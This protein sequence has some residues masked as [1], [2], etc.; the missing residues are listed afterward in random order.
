M[1]ALQGLRAPVTSLAHSH[2]AVSYL[3]AR[4][5]SD[6]NAV[7]IPVRST[8][9]AKNRLSADLDESARTRLTL[10]MMAD[11]VAAAGAARVVDRVFVVS[12]DPAL[13][14]HA[15]RS[16]A[17]TIAEPPRA[18][19]AVERPARE[20]D[21]S[22]DDAGVGVHGGLNRAVFYAARTLAGRG[23]TSV[24]TIPGDVPLIDASEIDEI[25][26][27]AASAAVVIVPSG[28]GTGT[29]GLL[30]S[31]PTVIAP[32]F[33]GESL[34]AH[35]RACRASALAYAL[36]PVRSFALD[37]DTLEDLRLLA[38]SGSDRESAGVAAALLARAA[39][40]PPPAS[41]CLGG[42]RG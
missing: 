19:G 23:V 38:R 18:N 22:G 14:E 41:A 28:S 16:G 8:T 24:L 32:Q 20:H 42:S 12:G 39:V 3:R 1:A 15:R 4:F 35:V 5:H 25:F 37:I 34:A 29:N 13:L 11:M 7:L 36:R 21:T 31:P 6:M 26:S 40:P 2:G 10:A 17:G 27:A 33:E 9:G 30:T